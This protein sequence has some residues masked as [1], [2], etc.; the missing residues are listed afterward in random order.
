MESP[1]QRYSILSCPHQ[2][3]LSDQPK[4]KP[5]S[6]PRSSTS[7]VPAPSRRRPASAAHLG[8]VHRA[9]EIAAA[10]RYG[11]RS[12]SP[13]RP[14]PPYGEHG[15]VISRAPRSLGTGIKALSFRRH[16]CILRRKVSSEPWIAG[17]NLL[18]VAGN[19][20]R[21]MDIAA[22]GSECRCWRRTRFRQKMTTFRHGKKPTTSRQ[23]RR[24]MTTP[25]DALE[26]SFHRESMI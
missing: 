14:L 26:N 23:Y 9:S 21:R 6:P 19:V 4:A 24:F 13:K 11:P 20:C 18:S 22:D 17:H 25:D 15:R 8:A 16:G 5:S 1:P 7:I 2:H 10:A 3:P 12:T